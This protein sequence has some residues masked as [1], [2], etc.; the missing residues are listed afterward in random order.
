MDGSV[1]LRLALRGLQRRRANWLGL[2]L[3]LQGLLGLRHDGL[4]RA[5]LLRRWILKRESIPEVP[6][7]KPKQRSHR[8]QDNCTAKNL[9]LPRN[10][11]IN[12]GLNTI[13][14]GF[15]GIERRPQLADA[16]LHLH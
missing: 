14:R 4:R 11:I 2:C 16:G 15:Q 8:P 5:Y 9:V 10:Q 12:L 1:S 7:P 13:D 3:R 6:D